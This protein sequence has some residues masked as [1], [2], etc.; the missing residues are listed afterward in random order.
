MSPFH[1][2]FVRQLRTTTALTCSAS[3]LVS[4][5]VRHIRDQQRARY[6]IPV[7]PSVDKMIRDEIAIAGVR[8]GL[9]PR[10]QETSHVATEPD[11]SH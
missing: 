9:Q 11:T 2:G 10:L 1:A 5:N 3:W 4:E 6:H 8:S 7:S